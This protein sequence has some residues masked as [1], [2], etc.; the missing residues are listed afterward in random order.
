MKFKNVFN[1]IAIVGAVFLGV[2]D[3]IYLKTAF[4][5]NSGAAVFQGIMAFNTP[6]ALFLAGT[7]LLWY[8]KK[9]WMC[10][11]AI[12]TITV[13]GVFLLLR[14][15]ALVWQIG[16][17]L[18]GTAATGNS[19][20]LALVE[21]A[22]YMVLLAANILL[23]LRFL[24]KRLKI[25]VQAVFTVAFLGLI[26]DW[27]LIIKNYV[28]AFLGSGN[29]GISLFFERYGDS[30]NSGFFFS[31]IALIAYLFVFSAATDVFEERKTTAAP[32]LKK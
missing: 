28:S 30:F 8:F 32:A 29:S 13:N 23:M 3:V 5:G 19:E 22:A 14:L 17:M 10:P 4:S 7:F 24:T 25:A 31:L 1:G 27:V 20:I 16:D 2:L 9:P 18:Q 6:C 15:L 26:I 11:L 12:A 21:F